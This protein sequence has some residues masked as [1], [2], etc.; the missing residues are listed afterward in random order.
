MAGTLAIGNERRR[1]VRIV[2]DREPT[3]R[4]CNGSHLEEKPAEKPELL[5]WEVE[6]GA[7]VNYC[8]LGKRLAT[9][10][11]LYR[12]HADGHALLQVLPDGKTRLIAK[13]SQLAPVIVDRIKM[14]VTKE[15][16]LVSELPTAAHLNSM[17]KSEEFLRQ[18]VPLDE[19]TNIPSTLTTSRLLLQ[20]TTMAVPISEYSIWGL[21]PRSP[22]PP[23]K[24]KRFST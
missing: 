18:F 1:C 8:N 3:V 20:A 12:H 23:R 13:G 19:V 22:T 11:D 4:G 14:I 7:A 15:G 21:T 6:H 5:T 24:S 17:L 16:K 9:C 2:S 10:G